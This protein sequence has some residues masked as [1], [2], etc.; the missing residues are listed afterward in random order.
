MCVGV[1]AIQKDHDCSGSIYFHI[2]V[3]SPV[4]C[5]IRQSRLLW[6][7]TPAPSTPCRE[8]W[9]ATGAWSLRWERLGDGP[10]Y[11]PQWIGSINLI[12]LL[13]DHHFIFRQSQWG[14]ADMKVEAFKKE[15]KA[16]TVRAEVQGSRQ[17]PIRRYQQTEHKGFNKL[18]V[19][20]SEI[21]IQIHRSPEE[22]AKS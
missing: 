22:Q 13:Y 9:R 17:N 19:R 10:Q 20:Q 5:R 3:V 7:R 6:G 1:I 21:G 12:S 18:T 11:G 2:G 8:T 16:H 14:Q 4:C 15:V